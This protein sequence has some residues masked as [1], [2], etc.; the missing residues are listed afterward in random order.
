M[1]MKLSINDREFVCH[2]YL[3]RIEY[4]HVIRLELKLLFDVSTDDWE[5]FREW[6]LEIDHNTQHK[7]LDYKRCIQSESTKYI[8]CFPKSVFIDS[9]RRIHVDLSVDYVEEIN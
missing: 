4:N 9:D 1:D 8:G 7:G 5:Y 3:D 2:F 6:M